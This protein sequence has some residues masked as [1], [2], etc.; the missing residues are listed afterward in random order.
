M[1]ETLWKTR[2]IFAPE[3]C[4]TGG[5]GR[6]PVDALLV[7]PVTKLAVQSSSRSVIYS[8][9]VSRNIPPPHTHA[10]HINISPCTSVIQ[11]RF[12]YPTLLSKDETPT[13]LSVKGLTAGPRL[14]C[15]ILSTFFQTT[16]NTQ[17][18]MGDNIK[19]DLQEM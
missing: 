2:Q 12:Q 13:S 10:N 14:R 3:I 19:M 18:L 5:H 7:R 1:L 4:I 17:A 6:T 8:E 15:F 16:W 9:L 11:Q